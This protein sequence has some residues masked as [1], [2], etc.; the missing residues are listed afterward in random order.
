MDFLD[1]LLTGGVIVGAAALAKHFLKEAQ[2]TK[3]RRSSPLS[4]TDGLTQN[5]FIQIANETAKRTP[6]V[7]AVEVTGMTV[8]LRIRSQSGLSTWT[9]EVDFND[10]GHL[11][12]SYWLA[13]GNSDSLIPK[14]FADELQAKIES[15][16]K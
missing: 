5:E 10:Y 8:D 7:A 12:G 6:R 14:H 1:N 9:A 13:T 11:T 4:F 3:R 15:R 2:E 16:I